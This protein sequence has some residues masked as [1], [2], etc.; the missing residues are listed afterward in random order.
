[1]ITQPSLF[2]DEPD[3]DFWDHFNEAP[4][5]SPVRFYWPYDPHVKGV[6]VG[7]LVVQ[8]KCMVIVEI[9]SKWY[10]FHPFYVRPDC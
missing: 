10:V 8:N 1:M 4:E 2:P 6:Y 3:Q 7:S 5:P 9:D